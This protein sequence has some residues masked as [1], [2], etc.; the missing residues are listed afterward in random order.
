MST[1]RGMRP[2]SFWNFD[3]SRRNSTS[4]ATSSFASSHPATSANV[5]GVVGLVDHPGLALAERERATP[6]AA[7]HLPHEEDPHADQQQHREPGNEDLR[8]ERL[9]LILLAVDL[10]AVLQQVAHHP[11]IA[12]AVRRELLL[13]GRRPV[14]LAAFDRRGFDAAALGRVHEF[15]IRNGILARL[16]RVELLDDDQ[17]HHEDHGPDADVLDQIVQNRLLAA[18]MNPAGRAP[19]FI[20]LA[21]FARRLE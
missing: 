14:D 13:V 8:Q 12:G 20:A 17:H 18:I 2:P 3:G 21:S 4:S 15:G 5:I 16:P 7:L 9:L 19:A 11:D 6:A 1:P 10:D